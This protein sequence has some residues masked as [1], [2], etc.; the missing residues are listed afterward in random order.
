MSYKDVYRRDAKLYRQTV[1]D[2]ET[3]AA[4]VKPILKS[5]GAGPFGPYEAMLKRIT[6]ISGPPH[7]LLCSGCVG[8]GLQGDT[9]CKKCYG[10]GYVMQTEKRRK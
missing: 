2:L 4:E 8:K 10:N 1:K 3:L 7:W 6:D 5:L 9:E